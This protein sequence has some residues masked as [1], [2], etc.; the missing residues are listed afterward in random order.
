[1]TLA[2]EPDYAPRQTLAARLDAAALLA[3]EGAVHTASAKALLAALNI[4]EGACPRRRDAVL[5]VWHELR[6]IAQDAI[7]TE[8]GTP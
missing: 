8:G 3:Y 6:R 5:R 4:D 2:F 1:M 7:H